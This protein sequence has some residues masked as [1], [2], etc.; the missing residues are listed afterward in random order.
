MMNAFGTIST[1]SLENERVSTRTLCDELQD[2]TLTRMTNHNKLNP[3]YAEASD[4][5]SFN[6]QNGTSWPPGGRVRLEGRHTAVD[7][8]S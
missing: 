4:S 3:H 1:S 6:H 5:V 2:K 8:Y 7:N